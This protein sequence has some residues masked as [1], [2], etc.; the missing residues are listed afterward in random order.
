MSGWPSGLRRCVQV[1]V[2]FC[3][4]G[5][6][7][8]FWQNI[9]STIFTFIDCT[10]LPCHFVWPHSYGS[11]V[12]QW[13]RAGPITQRSVDRNHALLK[14]FS[15]LSTGREHQQM[16]IIKDSDT[17]NIKLE[18]SISIYIKTIKCNFNHL[19]MVFIQVHDKELTGKVISNFG[20][21]YNILS[22]PGFEPGIFWSVVRRVIHC[23][24][25]PECS[26]RNT[27]FI[28]TSP[29]KH[30]ILII[31]AKKEHSRWNTHGAD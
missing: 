13:K 24:T 28:R 15:F 6:E 4:R 26:W 19:A 16:S 25:S 12:A 8:H 20:V 29:R 3:G 5:F 21:K 9:F 14:I 22:L 1:A 17:N 31:R 27:N 10:T 7:S 18:H 30:Y 2:H 11:R 23:A